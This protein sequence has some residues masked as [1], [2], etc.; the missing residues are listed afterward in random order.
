MRPHDAGLWF[1]IGAANFACSP[2]TPAKEPTAAQGSLQETQLGLPQKVI[3]E[4]P[5]APLQ[6]APFS[7]T[8]VWPGST[9]LLALR[10]E[11]WL[12]HLRLALG[13]EVRLEL[14][15]LLEA[16]LALRLDRQFD[17]NPELNCPAADVCV[18]TQDQEP[19][20]MLRLLADPSAPEPSEWRGLLGLLSS[21]ADAALQADP[22]LRAAFHLS[23]SVSGDTV[24]ALGPN[25]YQEVGVGE[26]G[27]KLERALH[28]SRACITSPTRPLAPIPPAAGLGPEVATG[29]SAPTTQG[30]GRASER[31][32]RS[33]RQR[34]LHRDSPTLEPGRLALAFPGA[35][36]A[37]KPAVLSAWLRTFID[38]A[39]LTEGP[40]PLP[41]LNGFSIR[42]PAARVPELLALA[43][44]LLQS[45]FADNASASPPGPSPDLGACERFQLAQEASPPPSPA[46]H[47][48]FEG[49]LPQGVNLDVIAVQVAR[50]APPPR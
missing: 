28:G 15:L 30:P 3:S 4:E 11:L 7:A 16:W 44:H 32:P 23:R 1:L 41:Y 14:R 47:A 19:S 42:V 45:S 48:Y 38:A 34:L 27:R 33:T 18:R 12:S 17:P 46:L 22:I 36:L 20:R 10:P 24:L 39:K 2:T 43:E 26:L 13:D 35:S 6:V 29:V 50:G 31:A 21:Q 8:P 25:Y 37:S 40:E 49:L 5:P 9:T